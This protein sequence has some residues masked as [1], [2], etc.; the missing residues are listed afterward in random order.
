MKKALQSNIKKLY[1]SQFLTELIF[2][3]PIFVPFL[4]G[5]GFSMEQILL[6]EASFAIVLAILEIPSGYFADTYGRKTALILG[7]SIELIGILLFVLSNT[8][9]GFLLGELIIGVGASLCSGSGEALLYDSLLELKQE[10]TYKK[11]TGNLFLYG[12]VASVIGNVTGAMFAAIFLK[13]PFYL[14]LIPYVLWILVNTTL[15]EPKVHKKHFEKWGHFIRILKETFHDRKLKYFI[16]YAGIPL[17]FFLVGFW[18]YQSYMQFIG[19]P[20]FYFG[21]MIGGMNIFSGLCSK[22]AKEIEEYISP[23]GSLLLI[24]GLA[25]ITFL[26]I[27]NT[28]S[29]WIIPFLFITSGLWGFSTPIFGDFIQQMTTS[30]RR[31]TVI[32]I[33]SFIT[34]GLFFIFAPFLGWITDLYDIQF[35]FLVASGL[36]FLLSGLSLIMLK[37]QKIL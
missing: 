17:T 11:I 4:S 36:L 30:D 32:S 28:N 33:R 7:S 19:L 10:K 22:Y 31:A 12:R 14:T 1:L 29:L 9:E 23:K 35:A 2:F 24:P 25:I 37:K 5:L 18:L 27:G 34:R 13:L 15:H 3:I 6:L 20:I 26:I 16:I 8:F 21:I